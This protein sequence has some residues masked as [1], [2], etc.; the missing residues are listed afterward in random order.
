MR[1]RGSGV[2]AAS[3]KPGRLYGR[4]KAP[5]PSLNRLLGRRHPRRDPSLR[6]WRSSK[7]LDVL[8]NGGDRDG[9]SFTTKIV[10]RHRHPPEQA[11]MVRI[12]SPWVHHHMW[13]L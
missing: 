2:P 7:S 10:D 5:E 13:W 8:A 4:P 6:G 3:L 12:V 1:E 9:R 11:W